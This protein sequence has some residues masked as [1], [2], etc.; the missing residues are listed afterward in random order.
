M[1]VEENGERI[2]VFTVIYLSILEAVRTQRAGVVV[3]QVT[4]DIDHVCS[5]TSHPHH[6]KSLPGEVVAWDKGGFLTL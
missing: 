2:T 1:K 6:I 3:S 5:C 4:F